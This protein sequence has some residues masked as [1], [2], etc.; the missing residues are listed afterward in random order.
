MQA[1]WAGHQEEQPF[2]NLAVLEIGAGSVVPSIK[3]TG[4]KLGETSPC[5]IRV[6]PNPDECTVLSVWT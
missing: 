4:E 1:A 3:R 2:Q 6:N 5:F